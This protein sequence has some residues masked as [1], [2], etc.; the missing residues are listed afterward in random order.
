LKPLAATIVTVFSL[1]ASGAAFARQAA[2]RSRMRPGPVAPD[3][4]QVTPRNIPF[5][6][7]LSLLGLILLRYDIS[8]RKAGCGTRL[9][10]DPGEVAM[11][12]WDPPSPTL[13][14]LILRDSFAILSAIARALTRLPR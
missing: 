13:F 2:R 9:R 8:L 6:T 4:G 5:A 3:F 7:F 10:C 11:A 12:Q 14:L 1:L